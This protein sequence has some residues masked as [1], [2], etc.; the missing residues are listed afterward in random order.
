LGGALLAVTA[1]AVAPPPQPPDPPRAQLGC[2]A[3]RGTAEGLILRLD[4]PSTLAPDD[5]LGLERDGEVVGQ[6]R[7]GDLPELPFTLRV[8]DPAVLAG[9]AIAYECWVARSGQGV[10]RQRFTAAVPEVPPRPAA[11]GAAVAGGRVR[12]D[13]SGGGGGDLFVQVLRR[14]VLS[15]GPAEA[16]SPRLA[17][18]GWEDARVEP[19]RVYAYSLQ[20]VRFVGDVPWEGPLGPERYVE[21]PE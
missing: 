16:I 9:D 6:V 17:T 4:V 19:G 11:P 1:C 3:E 15:A 5:V 14:D 18:P 10:E 21:V 20:V 12:L 13:W 2:R 7:V 8:G